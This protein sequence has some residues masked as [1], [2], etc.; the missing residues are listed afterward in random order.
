MLLTFNSLSLI[1]ACE[2]KEG[3]KGGEE[4]AKATAAAVGVEV[5]AK[6]SFSELDS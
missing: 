4:K 5:A 2:R 6:V 3:G 1:F